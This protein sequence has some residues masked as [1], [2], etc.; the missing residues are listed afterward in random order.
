MTDFL[1]ATMPAVGH[2]TPLRPVARALVARGHRVRWYAGRVFADAV[3]STGAEHVP[4]SASIDRDL[5]PP[6]EVFP[7][8]AALTGVAQF[9][10]DMLNVFLAPAEQQVADLRASLAEHPADV[11][12]GDVGVLGVRL[13]GE[14]EDRPWVTVGIAPLT[15]PSR[16]TA[17]FGSALPPSATPLGRVRNRLLYAAFDRVV[18]RPVNAEFRALRERVGLP[19]ARATLFGGV[20]PYLFLQN[21]V[22]GLE[23]PRSDLPPQVHFVGSLAA[24]EPGIVEP[25]WW[26]DVE[27]ADRPV[28]HV[29][30]GT[31][32]NADLDDLVGP[33][34]RALADEDVL[35]VATVG[36][37]ARAV[38]TLP[39]NARAAAMLPYDRLL[40]R[41]S[42]MVTNGGY[43]G[44]QQALAHGVPL[45]VA[46]ASED[47]PE[48]A[49]RVAWAGAGVD[50]R[51]ATPS[52]E[53]IRAAV[54]TV[55][56]GAHT[57]AATRLREEYR[58]LDA[59]A[60][61]ADLLEAV[62][63]TGG[64]VHAS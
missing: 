34:L 44:V 52:P 29:T 4:M 56:D 12:V 9:R 35:V 20:S 16:D 30:Q 26:S 13:L 8:R 17:P 62:A 64:P 6:D 36:T 50:L 46:G 37:Q 41:V 58:R 42:A 3:T 47:K 54:R 53:A 55:L 61:S 48:V 49:A 45:V 43:G 59:G 39:T 25:P 19:S 5:R 27:T 51:T 1:F 15:M 32:A 18:L 31:V 40:P 21:G 23:Y 38:P 10:W 14:L 2:V 57:A 7:E 33:T 28:V 22:P 60:R 63:R 24:P 11:L